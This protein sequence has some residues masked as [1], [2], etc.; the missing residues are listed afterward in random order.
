MSFDENLSQLLILIPNLI[1]VFNTQLD[2]SDPL[3]KKSLE[4]LD[5]FINNVDRTKTIIDNR[6]EK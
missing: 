6:L 4:S 2:E 3:D 1:N 5:D